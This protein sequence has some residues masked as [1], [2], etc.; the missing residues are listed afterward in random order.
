MCGRYFIQET[1]SVGVTGTKKEKAGARRDICPG[2]S[3]DACVVID[4]QARTMPMEWGF[5]KEKGGLVINARAESLRER[6][7][8]SGLVDRQRCAL[9]ASGYYEWRRADHQRYIIELSDVNPFYLAGLYRMG[10]RGP[11]FVVLTQPP[12]DPIRPI[13]DR[14][15]VI[16]SDDIERD[17]W[18]IDGRLPD[19]VDDGGIRVHSD[20]DEQLR[21]PF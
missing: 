6:Q 14:M 5:R 1:L 10:E 20:G 16:L 8:F 19:G 3:T 13:H 11:E 2:A 15:P 18:L 21:M 9:P 7:M 4:G 17:A 12:A